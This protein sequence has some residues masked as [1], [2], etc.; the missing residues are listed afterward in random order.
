[1]YK[2]RYSH[3]CQ[4]LWNLKMA[5][6]LDVKTLHNRILRRLYEIKK[7]KITEEDDLFQEDILELEKLLK[8]MELRLSKRSYDKDNKVI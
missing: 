8:K 5:S 4:V 1:M 6:M 3:P 7:S 2:E